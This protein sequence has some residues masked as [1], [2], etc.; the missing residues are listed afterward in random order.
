[1]FKGGLGGAALMPNLRGDV[2]EGSV[3]VA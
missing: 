1:L 2:R 3:Q